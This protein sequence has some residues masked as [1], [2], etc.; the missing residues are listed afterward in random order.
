M[1]AIRRGRPAPTP[2]AG[3][4]VPA[5]TVARAP[6]LAP[7]SPAALRA[8]AAVA[9]VP[10][11]TPPSRGSG[12]ALRALLLSALALP[13]MTGAARASPDDA[14]Q[15][16][17]AR[18]QA[19]PSL[20]EAPVPDESQELGIQYSQY[21]EG[22][23]QLLGPGTTAIIPPSANSSV[24][25]IATGIR[26]LPG[27]APVKE[28]GEHVY[29]R[30]RLGDRSRIGFDH[31]EDLWSGASPLADLPAHMVTGAS[32]SGQV[33]GYFNGRGQALFQTQYQANANPNLFSGAPQKDV[34]ARDTQVSHAMGYASPE[35]RRQTS[36]K[37]GY[38]WDDKS[39]DVGAGVSRE[40]D[41][42]S[43]FGNLSLRRDWNEKR[44]SV[45]TGLSY[46][47][48][49]IHAQWD[50]DT[51][52]R[53]A[54]DAY[55]GAFN[56]TAPAGV[57]IYHN[58]P[59]PIA[60]PVIGGSR[61]D[62]ALTA[63]VTQVV[64]RDDLFSTGFGYTHTTGF[65]SNPWKGAYVLYPAM[66]E[67]AVASSYPGISYR[68]GGLELEHRPSLR[69]QFTWDTSYLHYFEGL[70]AAG[71][72]HYGLFLDNWGIAAH[73]I[74]GEWRQ[75]L[76]ERWTATP[77]LRYYTQKAADF[78]AP[79]F[80]A[81]SASILPQHHFSSD[82]RLSGFG[83]L[84]PSITLT[85][86]FSRGLRAELG[87]EYQRRSGAYKMGGGG[88]AAFADLHASSINVVVRGNLDSFAWPH[89][90]A[91]SGGS[92][93]HAMHAGHRHDSDVP[94]GVMAAHMM[95]EPGAVMIG[96]T[97]EVDRTGATL[98]RGTG[99]V[100]DPVARTNMWTNGMKMTMNMFDLMYAQNHWLNWMVTPQLVDSTMGMSMYEVVTGTMA[101][102]DMSMRN[103]M[104]NAGVGDT[105]IYALVRLWN[106]QGQHVHLT[107]GVSMPTGSVQERQVTGAVFPYDMQTGSG[108]WDY[109][110]AV[111]YTGA[112]GDSLWGAQ[113]EA[114]LRH[115]GRNSAGYELG[116][117]G[118]ASAWAGYQF[119]RWLS[120]TARFRY[121]VAGAI[122]GQFDKAVLPAPDYFT[123]DYVTG[124]YGGH[125]RDLGIGLSSS[126]GTGNY[127]HDR[128]G[129][130][131]LRPMHSNFTGLQAGRIGTL[132][133]SARFGF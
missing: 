95:D 109:K 28:E 21:R 75:G 36:I 107:Q 106:Q 44:T 1:A 13:G 53:M 69:N 3:R 57:Q 98:Y 84:S 83:T 40:S 101:Y 35:A 96:Y 112:A 58:V 88:D 5:P 45:T 102:M 89:W 12:G 77:R 6:V 85:H 63:G 50:T 24:T 64:N 67:P 113:I 119:A 124:N 86:E 87:W 55:P 23:R 125:F 110:P 47:R 42:L 37:Y 120:G 19:L 70:G 32:V 118:D 122:K 39:L 62:L 97:Y 73:T 17:S 133:L 115:P 128:V 117:G 66:P 123:S 91:L 27:M 105:G 121:S 126:L 104:A 61:R 100:A 16:A 22:A 14:V 132:V 30:L 20:D 130:E 99:P 108:T 131:W 9:R 43:Q 54:I 129:V 103:F 26:Q 116:N 71:Q 33:G 78:Y 46:T 94:A 72:L 92:D 111:V 51:F 127:A 18:S 11:A 38:D 90:P 15:A 79:Y 8:A 82:E 80:F 114:T 56:Q 10:K 74:D 34:Y 7:A 41:F 48:G 76:G 4:A 59:S 2:R 52:Q 65:L 68:V 29:L 49:D 60:A 25:G 81:A 93:A 31:V